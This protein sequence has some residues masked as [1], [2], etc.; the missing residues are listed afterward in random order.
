[1]LHGNI[2]D[3]EEALK[4]GLISNVVPSIDLEKTGMLLANDLVLN[5]SGTAMGLIKELLARER[6]ET[7]DALDYASHLNALTRITEDCKRGIDAL[8]NSKPIKW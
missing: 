2:V 7:G 4:L 8:L 6:H 5:N 1:M 3:A